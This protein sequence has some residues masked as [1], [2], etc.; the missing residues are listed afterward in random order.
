[1]WSTTNIATELYQESVSVSACG[2]SSQQQK[3]WL[4]MELASSMS[5]VRSSLALTSHGW[6][7]AVEF[8]MAVFRPFRGEIIY[9]RIKSSSPDGIIID[10]DFTSEVFVPY[11]N[12]FENSSFSHAENVWVWNSDGT[13]LFLDKGEPVLFRVEQ[14]EWVDKQPTP[15]LEE[16]KK[17][18]AEEKGVTWRLI[19]RWV[20][21]F[22]S[23]WHWLAKGSMNQAGL[24]PTLWW[25][26]QDGEDDAEMEEAE[27]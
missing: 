21:Y 8:R 9:G 2:I 26:E 11:Q 1:M 10:L 3:A 20:L 24:G 12:L 25:G 7:H 15:V 14:E 23:S 5:I 16:D 27:A 17:E 6:H 18:A 13:E 4:D 22:S 19:V